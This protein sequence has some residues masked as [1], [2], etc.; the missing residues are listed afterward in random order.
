MLGAHH[1]DHDKLG[2]TE[3]ELDAAHAVLDAKRLTLVNRTV[4]RWLYDA[5]YPS[6]SE[7]PGT[8]KLRSIVKTPEVPRRCLVPNA[9]SAAAPAIYIYISVDRMCSLSL[10]R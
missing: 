8:T 1:A 9:P 6:A 3:E 7:T 10:S 2:M 4:V 5:V